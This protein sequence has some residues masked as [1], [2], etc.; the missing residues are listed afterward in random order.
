[1]VKNTVH[2]KD[3]IGKAQLKNAWC[4]VATASKHDAVSPGVSQR[5]KY[6]N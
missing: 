4:K 6:H 3:N 5:K 2:V 1:L